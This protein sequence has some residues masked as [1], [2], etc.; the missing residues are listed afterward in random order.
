MTTYRESIEQTERKLEKMRLTH[1]L[2]QVKLRLRLLRAPRF[3][4]VTV[5]D[6]LTETK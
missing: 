6:E 4:P 5:D 2:E 3:E 1:D